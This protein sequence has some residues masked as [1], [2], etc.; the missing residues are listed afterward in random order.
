MHATNMG[1]G[2]KNKYGNFL[3][4]ERK[5]NNCKLVN[6]IHEINCGNGI[7]ERMSLEKRACGSG[8]RRQGMK[9]GEQSD[10]IVKENLKFAER[11][12]DVKPSIGTV[13]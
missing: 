4:R 3:E 11:L 13:A 2:N 6:R 10:Q 9:N 7:L 5:E 12:Q 8:L 1:G